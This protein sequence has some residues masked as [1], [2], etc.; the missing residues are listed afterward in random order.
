VEAVSTQAINDYVAGRS[1]LTLV[2]SPSLLPRKSVWTTEKEINVFLSNG[3]ASEITQ[4]IGGGKLQ[5]SI[6]F[7]QSRGYFSV[8][9]SLAVPD[10]AGNRTEFVFETATLR[11]GPVGPL[12]LPPVG[13]GWFDT[14]YLDDSLRIDSNSRN[15]L[16]ICESYP[17]PSGWS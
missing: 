1:F 11:L 4:T 13:R 8:D 10:P 12:R 6:P 3:W 15:D 16:L 7:V 9:G 14:V 17:L 5:N 2:W